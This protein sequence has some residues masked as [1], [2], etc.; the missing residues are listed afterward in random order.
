MKNVLVLSSIFALAACG[1][2]QSKFEEKFGEKICE[3]Y[4]T[5]NADVECSTSGDDDDG[6]AECADY[7]KKKAKECLDGTYTCNDEFGEGFEFL[8]IPDACLAVCGGGGDDDDDDDATGD[9]DD[10][11]AS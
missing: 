6:G 1:L 4:A 7:D 10:D 3:E 5:C 9:D 11:D 2:S 8:E